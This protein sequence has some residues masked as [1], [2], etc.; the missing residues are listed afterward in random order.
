MFGYSP[1]SKARFFEHELQVELDMLLL[2]HF[3]FSIPSDC[4]QTTAQSSAIAWLTS[5][6]VW[7]NEIVLFIVTSFMEYEDEDV[8]RVKRFKVCLTFKAIYF[9]L[10]S[11]LQHQSYNASLKEV[12]LPSALDQT[13]FDHDI[14]VWSLAS[15]WL[16][17]PDYLREI[18]Q[19]IS[20]SWRSGSLASAQSIARIYHIRQ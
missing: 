12:H 5:S 14:A 9:L 1:G 11:C 17:L 2:H 6:V 13:K 3:W 10:I 15:V 8:P 19:C 16:S 20:F 7:T 4:T 18:G